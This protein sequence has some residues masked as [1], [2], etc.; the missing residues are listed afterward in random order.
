MCL[1]FH[2]I[3]PA[4]SQGPHSITVHP[5]AKPRRAKSLLC[6]DCLRPNQFSDPLE[7]DVRSILLSLDFFVLL[8]LFLFFCRGASRTSHS[9]LE[10][11]E[12]ICGQGFSQGTEEAMVVRRVVDHEEDS[13]QQLIGHKQVVNVCPLVVLTTV[14]TTPLYQGSEVTTVPEENFNT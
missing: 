8:F 3:W 12:F 11:V 4:Q 6:F 1:N 7:E 14:A 2:S 9:C 10:E 5:L 13:S